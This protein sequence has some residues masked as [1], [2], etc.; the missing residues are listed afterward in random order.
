MY[1]I[2]SIS[3]QV[4]W[5]FLFDVAEPF[6]LRMDVDFRAGT[7]RVDESSCQRTYTIGQCRNARAYRTVVLGDT[8]NSH[9][10]V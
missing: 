2:Q 6:A 3:S 9:P 4:N 10:T 7:I 1:H 8:D 5:N